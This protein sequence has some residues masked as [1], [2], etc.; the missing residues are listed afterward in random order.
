MYEWTG[1][2][3]SRSILRGLAASLLGLTIFAGLGAMSLIIAGPTVGVAQSPS[4]MDGLSSLDLLTAFT[5][6]GYMGHVSGITIDAAN[7]SVVHAP[8]SSSIRVS[9]KPGGERWAGAYFLHVSGR[10][11]QGNWG[12]EPGLNLSGAIALTFWARGENASEQVEFKAGG[13]A[14]TSKRYRDDFEVTLGT[15]KLTTEWQQYTID[16]SGKNLEG[17][18]GAFAWIAQDSLNANGLTFYLSEL[19]FAGPPPTP[20]PTPTST[21]TPPPPATPAPTATPVP[22]ALAPFCPAGEQPQFI[23]Q[24]DALKQ[25]LGATMGNPL[26]CKHVDANTGDI[27]QQT[28]TGLAFYQNATGRPMFTDGSSQYWAIT[29]AGL[30]NWTG[31]PDGPPDIGSAD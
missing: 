7:T 11:P 21:P 5:P 23:D 10:Y 31:G 18:L 26:E 28:T 22:G 6:A 9:Y 2:R 1:L 30:V 27:Q 29:D 14:D 16:L 25:Q 3:W 19:T 13:V 17:V 8:A 20:T 15:K 4:L 24:L 12:D